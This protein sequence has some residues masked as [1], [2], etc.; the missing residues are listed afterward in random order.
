MMKKIS[1]LLFL[2][3][4]VSSAASAYSTATLHWGIPSAKNEETPYP[5]KE[6]HELTKKYDAIYMEHTKE[7]NIYLTF[8]NGYEN[9]FTPK[10]LDVLK[11]KKVPATFF[12]T[13][14]FVK[15]HPELVKRM[16]DEGHI[17][18][19]HTWHHPKLTDVDD[20]RFAAEL[21]KLKEEVGKITG[22][23]EMKYIRPPEGVFSEKTLAAAKG[24]G[25]THVFW[26]LAFMDWDVHNQHGSQYAYDNVMSKIHPGAVVL[27][28]TI[29][30][31]NAG[32]L[33]SIIDDLRE[34]GYEF[35]S[36]DDVTAKN[37]H[38]FYPPRWKNEKK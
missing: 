36:L 15:E 21:S 7:K 28:H 12:I 13:G 2:C 6:F 4:I 38:K 16:A 17:I 27:L 10:I 33:A 19:N 29:S 23:K 5:G 35:H 20:T 3:I 9:G 34:K 22:Q 25:Y 31:D 1:L 11:E 8:D 14:Q 32:A 37:V 30:S 18:G 26:S 24:L